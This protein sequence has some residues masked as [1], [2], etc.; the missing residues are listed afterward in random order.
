LPGDMFKED[1][2][3]TTGTALKVKE[4]SL[5]RRRKRQVPMVAPNEERAFK[6][7][8]TVHNEYA[9]SW[10][11]PLLP[12]DATM[13]ATPADTWQPVDPKELQEV[14]FK[15]ISVGAESLISYMQA[16]SGCT[17]T[18]AIEKFERVQRD[19]ETYAV[20][21]QQNPES[22][23]DGGPHAATGAGGA[24]KV[25]GAFNPE[26]ETATEGASVTDAVRVALTQETN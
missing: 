11:L 25:K 14:Y 26:I 4:R 20:L 10:G 2:S 5:S 7:L 8:V 18:Q 3:V 21:L 23:I 22:I 13:K 15:D 16:K 17:R 12:V 1:K 6:K 24:Q 19:R 9:E